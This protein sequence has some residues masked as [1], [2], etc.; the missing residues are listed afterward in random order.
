MFLVMQEKEDLRSNRELCSVKGTRGNQNY[1]QRSRCNRIEC[2]YPRSIFTAKL[3][4]CVAIDR[5][6]FPEE[7]ENWREE[8]LALGIDVVESGP[9]VRSSYHAEEQ[10]AQFSKEQRATA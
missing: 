5:W 7:F 9:L 4:V 10:S 8:A 6:G 1:Y 3:R 2:S